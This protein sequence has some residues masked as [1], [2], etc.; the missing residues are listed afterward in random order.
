MPASSPI[1]RD[2]SPIAT[3]SS[4][5]TRAAIPAAP[6][7]G[8][9]EELRARC[10]G[11]RCRSADQGARRR[12]GLC[13]RNQRRRPDRAQP[14]GSPSGAG[15]RAGGART[16]EH[17][18]AE[19]PRRRGGRDAGPLRH[20]SQRRRRGRDGKVLWRQWPCRR[21][22]TAGSAA[23]VRH[24]PRGHGDVCPG[25]RQFRVLAC[26]RHEAAFALPSRRRRAAQRQAAASSWR[27]ARSRPG[28]R[29]TRMA[30]A[31]AEK[32]GTEPV[33]FPGDHMGFGAHADTFAET[34]HRAFGGK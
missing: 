3:R 34:L 25:Q 30:T 28:S 12:T 23:G 14:R 16:P 17:D 21:T 10:A 22:A 18:A 2:N 24:V 29:S 6:F 32:L 11:R 4:P 31:L 13:V 8:A 7:D 27:S 15:A 1:C 20:L 19:R 33:R 9:P 26:P 5:T